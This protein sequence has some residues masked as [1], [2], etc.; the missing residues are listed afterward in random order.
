MGRG[1]RWGNSCSLVDDERGRDA[2][3]YAAFS[4]E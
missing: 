2:I 1:A 4:E 3:V